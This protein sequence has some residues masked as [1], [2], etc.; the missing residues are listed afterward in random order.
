ML[1]NSKIVA[2]F[3]PAIKGKSGIKKLIENGMNVMRINFSHADYEDIK[4]RIKYLAELN[5]EMNLYIPWLCD[6]KGPEI[7]VNKIKNDLVHLEKN[8]FI[9]I[10]YD[11]VVGDENKFSTTYQD[12]Y[13]YVKKG[14]TILINDGLLVLQVESI[15]DKDIHCKVI[16]EGDLITNKGCNVPNVDLKMPY[17]SQKDIFD[18]EFAC[19]Y[20]A[21]FIASS[22]TRNKEDIL[23]VREL[24]EKNNRSD[25]KVIAK[26]ENQQ[27]IDNLDDILE[28]ADGIM[29][30][31]GDLGSEIAME[32]VPLAQYQMCKKANKIGKPVIVATHML[33]SMER[34]PRP[35]RAEAG[36]VSR[37]IIDGA[38]AVM[39][40]G[41]T[42]R[43]LYPYLAVEDMAKI[44]AKSETV[45]NHDDLLK[46]YLSDIDNNP[47]DGIGLSAVEMANKI[48]A[49][50]I[51]CFT[52]TG[53]TAYK[54]SKYRPICPI[55]ALSYEDETLYSLALCWG[56]K[57]VK[58]GIYT[59]LEHKQEI[60]NELALQQG[61]Q[62]GDYVII[63]GGYPNK[64]RYTNF[65]IIH[66]IGD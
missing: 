66:Q 26:I 62:L 50:G 7:R 38:D 13:K 4:K 23:L 12:I 48:N 22:F 49:K 16:F 54:I 63:T 65:L 20:Q 60:V 1:R 6:T 64:T 59:E 11:E 10:V 24:C 17:L 32:E 56:V 43:G 36:D 44:A 30:A 31:R 42:A 9:D 33:D 58:K 47:Y 29:V 46:K 15:K 5:E 41:E 52:T 39:L 55:Y 19:S 37:A 3:G 27:G 61:L 28:V 34:N 2:T 8:S 51:F 35:T 45:I 21:N 40:S 14:N 25:M 57:G 18:I 53:E